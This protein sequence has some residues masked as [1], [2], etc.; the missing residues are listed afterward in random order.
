[1]IQRIQSLW[2]LLAA[3]VM[4]LAIKLPF[5]VAK[6]LES[7]AT[8][9]I[10]VDEYLIAFLIAILLCVGSLVIIFLFKRRSNQKRLIWLGILTSVLFIV[11][12]YFNVGEYRTNDNTIT[13]SFSIGAVCPILYII[14]MAL[15]YAGVRRDEKLIRS[16]DRLR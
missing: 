2:L 13:A 1:M 14:F 7:G 3:I 5:A 16:V 15:A 8:K 12:M 6:S 11:L 10:I 9:N 4:F